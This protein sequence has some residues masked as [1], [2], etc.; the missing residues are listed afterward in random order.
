M[1]LGMTMF[2]KPQMAQMNEK[3]PQDSSLDLA[4]TLHLR[5]E[6]FEPQ[7]VHCH[8]EVKPFQSLS[9]P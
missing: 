8:F 2:Y 4:L 1:A 9:Q 3:L 7:E 6:D 5:D